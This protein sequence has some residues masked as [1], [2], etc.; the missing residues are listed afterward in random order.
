MASITKHWNTDLNYWDLHPIMKTIKAFG[1]LYSSDKSK[2]KTKSSLLMWAIA[3]YCDTHEEN[4]WR[5]TAKN[6]CRILIKTDVLKDDKFDW[7]HPEIKNLI[8]EYDKKCL[9]TSEREL[10]RL[11]RKFQ[12]RGDFIDATKYS[13]DDVDASG[14]TIKGTADQLDK[15]FVNSKKIQDLLEDI[16]AQVDKE[17]SESQLKGGAT[18][19]ASEKGML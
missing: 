2:K 11:E 16:R 1:D 12:E 3:M 9:T 8:S 13:L 15:M 4:P 17:K 19:S 10:K 7:E 5:N 6:E 14:K 18:K